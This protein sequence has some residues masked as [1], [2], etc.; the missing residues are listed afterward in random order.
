MNTSFRLLAAGM[1]LGLAAALPVEAKNALNDSGMVQCLTPAGQLVSACGG[2]G[3]DGEFGRD[4]TNASKK[5]GRLGF[6]FAK[7]CN[8]GQLAG[9]GT[10]SKSA[11]LGNGPDDWGCTADKVTG[12][13]WEVKT[14]DGGDRDAD[15]VYTQTNQ[16]QASDASE[17]VA[18]IN[19]R[20]LCGASD[21]RLPS[22]LE[23]QSLADHGLPGINGMAIDTQWF[24]NQRP[25]PYWSGDVF[26]YIHDYGWLADLSNG[27]VGFQGRT[28][29][30]PVML[31]RGGAL[32][33]GKRYVANGAEVTDTLTRMVWQ[34]CPLGQSWSGTAC[35]GVATWLDWPGAMA[36]AKAAATG[37]GL[38]WRLPNL[39]ELNS[40]VDRTQF[41]PSMDRVAFPWPQS[42]GLWSSTPASD[43]AGDVWVSDSLY[44]NAYHF[45]RN[46]GFNAALLVRPAP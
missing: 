39:K 22:A 24:P 2:T 25:F 21:W 26:S 14:D 8:S 42:L 4:V 12:L 46:Y 1:A 3:Q 18:L 44:G 19:G 45:D 43:L 20:G 6:S 5:D 16:H 37:S 40:L 36:A 17:F 29:P 7:V 27:N 33:S 15:L 11:A 41:A 23:L 38:P 35:T 30:W 10:C 13:T 32:G 31:V 34:R 9:K 28:S